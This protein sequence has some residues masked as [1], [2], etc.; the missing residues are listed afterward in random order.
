MPK[1]LTAL[2]SAL[3]F[4]GCMH[5]EPMQAIRLDGSRIR[6]D[7]VATQDFEIARAVCTADMQKANLSG[8]TFGGGGIASAVARAE[9]GNAADDVFK[10]CMAQKG[11]AIVPAN[12]AE[13]AVAHY[14]AVH[15]QRTAQQ[16]APRSN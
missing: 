16:S 15:E 14:R 2:L 1:K 6:G 4:S 3:L 8:V 12:Q 11:Y 5:H 10:G 13:Q 7:V 9:R